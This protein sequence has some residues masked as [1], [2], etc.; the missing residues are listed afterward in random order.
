[1]DAQHN[2]AGA[3]F[4]RMG[5]D[6]ACDVVDLVDVDVCGHARAGGK[7]ARGDLR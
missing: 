7:G 4:V 2:Q 6:A 5:Y 1:V 3:P